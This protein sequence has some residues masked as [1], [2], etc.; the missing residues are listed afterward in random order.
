MGQ[1]RL[2]QAP[3]KRV[4]QELTTD[5]LEAPVKDSS[6]LSASTRDLS[7]EEEETLVLLGELILRLN[8]T[9]FTPLVRIGHKAHVVCK[10]LI[11]SRAGFENNVSS[12]TS[13]RRVSHAS[14]NTAPSGRVDI[15]AT[16]TAN[17][18]IKNGV[19]EDVNDSA[20]LQLRSLT[21]LVSKG[22]TVR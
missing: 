10:D 15:E 8:D 4:N 6:E 2:F 13:S 7:S 11:P 12:R 18:S 16:D 20:R 17:T 22:G 19:L 5:S 1:G 9:G 3:F 14:G 21:K